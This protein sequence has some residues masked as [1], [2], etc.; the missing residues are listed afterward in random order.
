MNKET[1]DKLDKLEKEFL[2]IKQL[3][4]DKPD[5]KMFP[6]R[7]M[8]AIKIC[9]DYV[10]IQNENIQ[11]TSYSLSDN[12]L[13]KVEYKENQLII[14]VYYEIASIKNFDFLKNYNEADEPNTHLYNF[15]NNIQLPKPFD[16]CYIR[17]FGGNIISS[18]N[19]F[20]KDLYEV[21]LGKDISLMYQLQN[22]I[23]REYWYHT[24]CKNYEDFKKKYKTITKI[25]KQSKILAKGYRKTS[26]WCFGAAFVWFLICEFC[27]F[28]GFSLQI[29]DNIILMHFFENKIY[30][31]EIFI[32]LSNLLF[33]LPSF[34]LCLVGVKFLY[35]FVQYKTEEREFSML[36]SYLDKLPNDCK[37]EKAELIKQLAPHFFPDK[38]ANKISQSFLQ[39][40][41][42]KALEK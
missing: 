35:L 30:Q 32:F 38:K 18:I 24:N 3:L 4:K 15:F 27:N 8:D 17:L 25:A 2:E 42:R 5:A 22:S 16:N 26:M 37:Q 20:Q 29:D 6:S 12:E 1:Q 33:K 40:L 19:Q 13:K 23:Q 11:Q 34:V 10:N 9:N 31:K 39:E 28:S 36:D 7:I 21:Y 14:D 41:L